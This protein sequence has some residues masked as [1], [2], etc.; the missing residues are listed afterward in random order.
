M[1]PTDMSAFAKL[2]MRLGVRYSK[3]I[4]EFTIDEYWQDLVEF[5]LVTIKAAIHAHILN[6]DRGQYFPQSADVIRHMLGDSQSRALKAWSKVN[7]AIRHI[8][9]YQSLVFDDCLIHA[10]ID[11]MGGWITLCHTS[12]KEL[13]FITREFQQRYAAYVLHPPA[14]YPQAL[15]GRTAWQ[16]GMQGYAAPE[17]VIFGDTDKAQQVYQQGQPAILPAPKK[18]L[19]LAHQQ[20][21]PSESFAMEIPQKQP[22]PVNATTLPDLKRNKP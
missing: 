15:T 5:D 21:S 4:T 2:W 14:I 19:L 10:V 20:I 7:K 18:L 22:L 12:A 1:K 16:N 13:P 6:A 3:T 11:E 8:G 9:S 17:A